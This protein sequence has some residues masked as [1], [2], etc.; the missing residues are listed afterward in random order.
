MSGSVFPATSKS[1][2]KA[3]KAGLQ[4]TSVGD[5]AAWAD[6]IMILTPD[7]SQGDIYAEEIA[8]HM[9]TGK[10]IMFAPRFQYPLW[11]DCASGGD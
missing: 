10:T 7:Q 9:K 1:M 6:V 11:H 4:V 3:K 5:A 8:Q 2:E